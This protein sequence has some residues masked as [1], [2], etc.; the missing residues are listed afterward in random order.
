MRLSLLVL[1]LFLPS[2]LLSQS[3]DKKA[4]DI[5]I[6]RA[7]E[8]HSSALVIYHDDKL[9]FNQSFDDTYVPLDAMSAT[10]SFVSL[11]I[12]LLIT[13]GKLSSID[14]YVFAYYP[15][16]NQGLKKEIT[17][18]HLLNHTSGI[19]SLRNATEVYSSPDYVQLALAA[20]I[21]DK[22]GSSFFL[23]Q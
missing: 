8:T 21:V 2:G 10:K 6:A 11:G 7:K 18:R 19:Q 9:I 14:E 17:I 22:P 20:D 15:E 1:I 16:W 23:Q 13:E 3:I 4:L 12:G 5:L